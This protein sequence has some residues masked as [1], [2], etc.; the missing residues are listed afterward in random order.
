[1]TAR[2]QWSDGTA[3]QFVHESGPAPGNAVGF[4]CFSRDRRYR[5]E[6]RRAWP[7]SG[8]AM[9]WIMLNPSTAGARRDDATIR[10]CRGFANREGCSSIE[11][12][13]LFAL[14][15]TKPRAL[16]SDLDP[17]GLAGGDEFI[18]RACEGRGRIVV[19][20]WGANA[21]YP[22][23]RARANEVL[24]LLDARRVSYR[25]LGITSGGHPAHPLRLARDTPLQLG[26]RR[27][28]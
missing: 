13:N 16:L 23:L 21:E 20:A 18:V 27:P 26:L 7:G 12:V 17:V 19:V 24:D 2:Q 22:R 8:Q 14:V 1:M 4:A 10:R 3:S 15:A 5:W 6:L 11:V 9:T 28:R 25:A